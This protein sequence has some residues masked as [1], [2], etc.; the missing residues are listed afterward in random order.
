[1]LVMTGLLIGVGGCGSAE[2]AHEEAVQKD[3]ASLVGTW[4]VIACESDGEKV[5]EEI[6][7]G[8]VVRW[9][10]T[11]DTITI[12]VESEFK[13][14][15]RYTLNPTKKPTT[16]DLTDKNGKRILGI[17]A[18]EGDSLKVCW[19]EG[20]TGR[21]TEFVTKPNSGLALFVFQR[22]TR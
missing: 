1:M 10:V 3:K 12:K 8:E 20:K 16:I 13:E 6:L 22:E 4:K 5:P 7:R 15:D 11:A 19:L 14:E 2:D 21:P 17:Y 9:I 18:V